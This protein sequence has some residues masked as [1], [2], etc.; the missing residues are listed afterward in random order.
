MTHFSLDHQYCFIISVGQAGLEL[1]QIF[2]AQNHPLCHHEQ[3][4]WSIEKDSVQKWKAGLWRWLCDDA[5]PTCKV[6]FRNIWKQL[7]HLCPTPS[8]HHVL[9]VVKRVF[10]CC[11]QNFLLNCWHPFGSFD[12]YSLDV[13][14]CPGSENLG[15]P[16]AWLS[17]QR[18]ESS[19]DCKGHPHFRDVRREKKFHLW[20]DEMW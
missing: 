14:P 19:M 18:W 12:A 8:A 2:T 13:S 5:K 20:K 4:R 16:Q 11:F 15:A 9:L 7:I 10:L 1:Y 17:W 3:W 6:C